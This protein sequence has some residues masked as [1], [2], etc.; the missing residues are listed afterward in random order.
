MPHA[1]TLT[2]LG[3]HIPEVSGLNRTLGFDASR[4]REGPTTSDGNW[5]YLQS[6]W[7]QSERQELR[8]VH[9][10]PRKTTS[11]RSCTGVRSFFTSSISKRTMRAI[12]YT[13]HSAGHCVSAKS[14]QNIAEASSGICS[15]T[16]SSHLLFRKRCP[17]YPWTRI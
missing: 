10:A 8:L 16:I 3:S 2:R 15:A 1:L 11:Q 13:K 5:R 6:P 12:L 4:S 17:V 9:F 14:Q 7:T